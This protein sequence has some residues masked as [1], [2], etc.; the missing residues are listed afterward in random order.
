MRPRNRMTGL[1]RIA[2]S[3]RWPGGASATGATNAAAHRPLTTRSS[4][5][6]QTTSCV[7]RSSGPVA[8]VEAMTYSSAAPVQQAGQE[9]ATVRHT[10]AAAPSGSRRAQTVRT[11]SAIPIA[12]QTK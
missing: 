12:N 3:G 1:P 7:T 5:D 4:K 9:S 10:R 11:A 2:C 8:G 6:V